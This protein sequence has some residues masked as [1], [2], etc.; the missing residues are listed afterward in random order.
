MA[1]KFSRHPAQ[2]R[3]V[4]ARRNARS[5]SAGKTAVRAKTSR[6]KVKAF[7]V[8]MRA[9]GMRLVQMWLPETRTAEFAAEARRQSH[10]ANVSSFAAQDQAWVDDQSNWNT[11]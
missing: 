2:P 5:R 7:R 4:K 1:S 9:K 10:L 11:G 6:E 8:R 3:R